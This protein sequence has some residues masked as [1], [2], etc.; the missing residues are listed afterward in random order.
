MSG[1]YSRKYNENNVEN[2]RS[3]IQWME[4]KIISSK[5]EKPKTPDS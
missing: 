1:F 4:K 3:I 2:H 5:M